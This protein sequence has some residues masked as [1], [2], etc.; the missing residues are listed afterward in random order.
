VHRSS[1]RFARLPIVKCVGEAIWL[2]LTSKISSAGRCKQ[3]V[4]GIVSKRLDRPSLPVDRRA[5]IKTMPQP[6]RVRRRGVVGSRRVA[7]L[8]R[9]PPARLLRA[10]WSADLRGPRRHGLSQKTL[11]TLHKRLRPRAFRKIPLAAPPPRDNRFGRPL[12]LARVHWLRPELVAE[13]TYLSWPDH[14]LLRHT[15]FVGLRE[16]KPASEVRRET[17]QA[18]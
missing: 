1:R 9:R 10:E 12:E 15:V 7:T 14:G 17:P 2:Y 3:S 6:R 13:I 8:C 4:E 18:P 11:A 16:D 5:G